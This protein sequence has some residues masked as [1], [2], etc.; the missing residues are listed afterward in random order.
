[1]R[2]MSE[3]DAKKMTE[4]IFTGQKIHAIKMYRE[5]SG[6]GLKEAKDFID[7]MEKQLREECPENF[8]HAAKTGC[9]VLLAAGALLAVTA[10]LVGW[11]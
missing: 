1:M 7:Q 11:A 4:F 8:T 6:L 9:S 2:E 10:G 3:E 5:A